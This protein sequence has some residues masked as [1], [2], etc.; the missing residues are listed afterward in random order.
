MFAPSVAA[1]QLLTVGSIMRKPGRRDSLWERNRRR[2]P[3]LEP[4]L[5]TGAAFSLIHAA[6][7][8]CLTDVEWE[9]LDRF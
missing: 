2:L 1:S 9:V 3:T 5:E 4:E 8:T 7:G 6:G